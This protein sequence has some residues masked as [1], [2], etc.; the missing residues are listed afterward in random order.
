MGAWLLLIELGATSGKSQQQQAGSTST[1]A[2]ED[3]DAGPAQ[4]FALADSLLPALAMVLQAYVDCAY[5]NVARPPTAP[6]SQVSVSTGSGRTSGTGTPTVRRMAS[7]ERLESSSSPAATPPLKKR[8]STV[9]EEGSPGGH[10]A[11]EADAGAVLRGVS[12]AVCLIDD[13]S[14]AVF[15]RLLALLHSLQIQL[16]VLAA[17]MPGDCKE[18]QQDAAAQEQDSG[19]SLPLPHAT[20]MQMLAAANAWMQQSAGSAAAA[21]QQYEHQALLPLPAVALEALAE[22]GMDTLAA[23]QQLVELCSKALQWDC[24]QHLMSLRKQQQQQKAGGEGSSSS[25]DAA[26]GS[27]SGSGSIDSKVDPAAVYKLLLDSASLQQAC[28]AAVMDECLGGLSLAGR[29]CTRADVQQLLQ[30][31]GTELLHI[32]LRYLEHNPMQQHLQQLQQVLGTEGNSGVGTEAA[33][34]A[35]VAAEQEREYYM[36]KR[37]VACA[38]VLMEVCSMGRRGVGK[39]RGVSHA[40]LPT[41]FQPGLPTVS[42]VLRAYRIVGSLLRY[43]LGHAVFLH[44]CSHKCA[45][46]CCAVPCRALPCCA[47]LC[48]C[49]RELAGIFD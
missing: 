41:M 15:K 14:T 25:N 28:G 27:S 37:C 46:L 6:I 7:K 34:A 42:M 20:N 21:G 38:Q 36:P 33:D 47:V 19:P 35:A 29:A 8:G 48:C 10:A 45:V 17:N 24:I 1:A 11:T 16:L 44:S 32:L 49:R 22:V 18:Q 31:R 43:M 4:P 39:S 40:V 12:H 30:Q 5:A 3:A 2:A 23:A 26:A 13:A 9:A